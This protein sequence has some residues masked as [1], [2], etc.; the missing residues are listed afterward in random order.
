M[1][2][3]CHILEVCLSV[4]KGISVDMVR[5]FCRDCCGDDP[6]HTD[7]VNFAIGGYLS[8]GVV[9][10]AGFFSVPVELDQKVEPVRVDKGSHA[11]LQ[12]NSYSR[13]IGESGLGF[14]QHHFLFF[15]FFRVTRF[16]GAPVRVLVYRVTYF[17]YARQWAC[18]QELE[19][20]PSRPIGFWAV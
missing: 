9:F 11:V 16:P 19:W 14:D 7:K 6:V 1:L 13:C 4:V 2:E 3:S 18:L 20:K 15:R 12:W 8:T 17:L 10:T 5:N